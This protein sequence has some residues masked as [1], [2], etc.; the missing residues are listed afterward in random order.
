MNNK[1]ILNSVPSNIRPAIQAIL[2][3]LEE[4]ENKLKTENN[5]NK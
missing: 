2:D 4:L 1:E 5:K 3:R